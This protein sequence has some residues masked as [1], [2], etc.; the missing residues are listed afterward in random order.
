MAVKSVSG[1]M[2]IGIKLQ[3]SKNFITVLQYWN[4]E[5]DNVQQQQ[6]MHYIHE[7]IEWYEAKSAEK[8]WKFCLIL[9]NFK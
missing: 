5:T 3:S 6:D 2:I 4:L 7:D 1:H 8:Q 9:F